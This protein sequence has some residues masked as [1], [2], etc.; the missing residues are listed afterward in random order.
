[1]RYYIRNLSISILL[2]FILEILLLCSSLFNAN[3]IQIIP[4]LGE[5]TFNW[6]VFLF[7]ILYNISSYLLII[8]TSLYFTDKYSEFFLKYLFRTFLP[9][10]LLGLPVR[11]L[12]N[13]CHSLIA[14][15]NFSLLWQNFFFIVLE[16]V[17]FY[18]IL[19]ACF[20][21]ILHYKNI[22]VS[23]NK[24]IIQQ[25]IFILCILFMVYVIT[26]LILQ[27]L[28]SSYI[29]IIHKYVEP[30]LLYQNEKLT[31]LMKISNCLCLFFTKV[32]LY[33][34]VLTFYAPLFFSF[35][36]IKNSCR[37]ILGVGKI[38]TLYLVSILATMIVVFLV[39]NMCPILFPY[40]IISYNYS[41]LS[42][43]FSFNNQTFLLCKKEE[44]TE[45]PVLDYSIVQLGS[46]ATVAKTYEINGIS[47]SYETKEFHSISRLLID[48]ITF[49]NPELAF[50]YNKESS[51]SLLDNRGFYY[52]Y[53]KNKSYAFYKTDALI[54]EDDNGEIR[55][56]LFST[57]GDEYLYD[58]KLIA[59][60][61]DA[62]KQ[63]YFSF[64]EGASD[65]LMIY[66]K[67]FIRPILNRFAN[68]E[69]TKEEKERNKNINI[70]YM[71]NFAQNKL[72][73]MSD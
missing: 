29:N 21:L 18:I 28:E 59:A 70:D 14:H 53:S 38:T 16:V 58:A 3:F 47:S 32:A 60:L 26:F 23:K 25:I 45:I 56:F 1:M 36:K 20:L 5:K 42:E 62:V 55:T 37:I 67:N 71:I 8:I 64:I 17:Y 31:F 41:D 30:N 66:D 9:L 34:F 33:Y 72:S 48:D 63:G 12:V 61:E 19:H 39:K 7:S 57:N 40:Q 24:K 49:T 44:N 43:P 10:I 46:M 11:I 6:P 27:N 35:K 68:G 4:Y 69:L 65:Y 15:T 22:K 73:S 52:R 51:D 2:S 13:L 54:Y 50:H